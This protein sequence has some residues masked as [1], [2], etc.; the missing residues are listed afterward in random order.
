MASYL[1]V[2]A[3]AA[4]LSNVNAAGDD[5]PAFGVGKDGAGTAIVMTGA[6]V[7]TLMAAQAGNAVALIGS[8]CTDEE[9]RLAAKVLKLGKHPGTAI[10]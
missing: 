7:E 6:E 3:T 5:V 1:V 4:A 2:N 8:G 9:K 10:T